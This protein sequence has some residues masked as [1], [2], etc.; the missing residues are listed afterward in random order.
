M[1]KVIFYILAAI[2]LIICTVSSA[3]SFVVKF[4]GLGVML[5]V[6]AYI[7][8]ALIVKVRRENALK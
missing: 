2:A 1:R 7:D 3:L 4:N 5:L 6:L 8:G